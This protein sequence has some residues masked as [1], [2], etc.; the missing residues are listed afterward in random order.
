M[1]APNAIRPGKSFD[2]A[3]RGF[4]VE[5]SL[6]IYVSIVGTTSEGSP[7]NIVKIVTISKTAST[8]ASKFDVSFEFFKNNF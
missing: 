7:V 5:V 4:N 3:V 8:Y 2:V 6:K 1:I